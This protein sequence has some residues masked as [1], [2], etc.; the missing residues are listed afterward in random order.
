[1]RHSKPHVHS[2]SLFEGCIAQQLKQNVYILTYLKQQPRVAHAGDKPS[3]SQ[4]ASVRTRV[5]K[6][7]ICVCIRHP[8]LP[9]MLLPSFD[10]RFVFAFRYREKLHCRK[11][12]CTSDVNLN[13]VNKYLPRMPTSLHIHQLEKYFKEKL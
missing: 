11:A 12:N 8:H 2:P 9:N 10:I 13:H 7:T 1:M 4:S 3:L 5:D 6:Q